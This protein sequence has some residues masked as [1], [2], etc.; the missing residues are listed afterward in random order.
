MEH[1]QD[2]AIK[3]NERSLPSR[4]N[5]ETYIMLDNSLTGKMRELKLD[6]MDYT[7][8][9]I[10]QANLLL[11]KL[12][13]P[14]TIVVTGIQKSFKT[15]ETYSKR[16]HDNRLQAEATAKLLFDYI[17]ANP[18]MKQSDLIVLMTWLHMVGYTSDGKHINID[19]H[20]IL[21]G[22][23]SR[24]KVVILRE[25]PGQY[26]GVQATAHEVAHSLGASHDGIGSSSECA[27]NKNFLMYPYEFPPTTKVFSRC[28]KDAVARFLR[29]DLATCLFTDTSK[30]IPM[31]TRTK[32]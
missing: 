10:S 14:A 4:Y 16:T 19:G 27:E 26:S 25:E 30:H 5:I 21:G 11:R 2:G 7:A 24:K 12:E 8:T 15:I 20:T 28:T 23:C 3:L 6:T 29:M 31:H 22:A 1:F 17:S 18:R 9:L 32:N 13:P